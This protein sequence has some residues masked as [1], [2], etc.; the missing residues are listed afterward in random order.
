[1]RIKTRQSDRTIKRFNRADNLAQKTKNGLSETKRTAE[2]LQD[3]T[4]ESGVD[5]AGTRIQE[6]EK[7]IGVHAAYG[8]V[9]MGRWGMRVAGNKLRSF[10][11]FRHRK[12]PDFKVKIPRK[13]LP[14]PK[15][16]AL[17]TSKKLLKAPGQTTRTSVKVSQKAAKM[18]KQGAQTTVKVVKSVIKAIKATIAFL[19]ETIALIIAGGWI[20]VVII[21]IIVI[22]ALVVGSASAVFV[23]DE[24][25][26][27]T[28]YCGTRGVKRVYC[29][30]SPC[31]VAMV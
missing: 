7:K 9:R 21:I 3:Q 18:I 6:R 15:R 2:Q 24:G 26:E 19:K 11:R 20:S 13:Q 30:M 25:G 17:S 27:I 1:M 12:M 5:Y 16:K 8:M 4:A 14:M 29:E 28:I 23:V 22:V 10:Y 31:F